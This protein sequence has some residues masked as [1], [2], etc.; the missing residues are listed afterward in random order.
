MAITKTVTIKSINHTTEKKTPMDPL[1]EPEMIW[2]AKEILLEDPEDEHLPI[3]KTQVIRYKKGD[4]VSKED[5]KVQ[6]MF[7]I[8]FNN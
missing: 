3:K 6:A 5:P 7:N 4:D 2:V 1:D 8:V